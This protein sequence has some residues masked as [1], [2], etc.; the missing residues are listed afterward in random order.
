MVSLVILPWSELAPRMVSDM[1]M[2]WVVL[3]LGESL[4]GPGSFLALLQQYLR[5]G[6]RPAQVAGGLGYARRFG[7]HRCCWV[8]QDLAGDGRAGISRAGA[9]SVVPSPSSSAQ[10]SPT[11][12]RT[13][14]FS[15]L[16]IVSFNAVM[17]DAPLPG[18][19]VLSLMKSTPA[20]I[21]RLSSRGGIRAR[22]GFPFVII[23]REG[24][25]Y[26]LCLDSRCLLTDA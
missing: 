6:V 1:A 12:A 13:E 22:R 18:P 17:A 25:P 4:I 19:E 23:K 5:E 2:K 7:R 24:S 14:F 20:T 10:A 11:L 21:K 9:G 26:R 8:G 15:C 16:R 3:A